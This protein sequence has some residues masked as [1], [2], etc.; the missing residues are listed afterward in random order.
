VC[1]ARLFCYLDKR[2][3]GQLCQA[4][5]NLCLATA[6]LPQ[7]KQRSSR[8]TATAEERVGR[9]NNAPCNRIGWVVCILGLQGA[10]LLMRLQLVG[11]WHQTQK[12]CQHHLSKPDTLLMPLPQFRQQQRQQQH[13][14][15]LHLCKCHSPSGPDQQQVLGRDLFA[16]L[17]IIHALPFPRCHQPTHTLANQSKQACFW[18]LRSESSLT[19]GL[20]TAALLK[21]DA[22]KAAAAPAAAPAA[23]LL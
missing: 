18:Q 5:R 12:S 16:H 11:D 1:L 17:C 23:A 14:Q 9:T 10:S 4:A 22:P 13:Q 19:A 15:Q 8:S 21:Q 6:A 7:R 20:S 2:C 3:F